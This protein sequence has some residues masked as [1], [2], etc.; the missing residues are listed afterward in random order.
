MRLSFCVPLYNRADSIGPCVES[1]LAQTLPP[2]ADNIANPEPRNLIRVLRHG[3][4]PAARLATWIEGQRDGHPT[5]TV[6]ATSTCQASRPKLS[7]ARCVRP[8]FPS[9]SRWAEPG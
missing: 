6:Y 7:T 4:L 8:I 3:S 2:A 1:L 5:A 9:Q